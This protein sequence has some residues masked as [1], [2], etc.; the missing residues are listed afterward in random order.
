MVRQ[1]ANGE[2]T[3]YPRKNKQDK[4]IGYRGSYWVRTA[5]GRTR[6]HVSGKTKTEALAALRKATA[7]RDGGLVFDAKNLKLGSYLDRWLQ[8]SVKGTVKQTTYEGYERLARV[9][10]VPT[11]GDAKLSLLTPAH[12]RALYQEKIASGLAATSV[13][14]IHALLHKALRQAVNDGLIPRNVTDAVKA[15]RQQRK[16]MKTFTPE[17]AHA[18]LDA[19]KDDRLGALYVVAI[20]TGVRQGELFGLR[21]EDVDLEAGTLS[22]HRTL[23]SA[24]G[25]P[26]FTTPKSDKAR[27]VRLTPQATAALRDHRKRQAQAHHTIRHAFDPL[28]REATRLDTSGTA[29]SR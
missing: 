27:R 12:I 11:L 8:D 29:A 9:H 16:E 2:G 4:V 1:R 21:W 13:Q 22:V 14:R 20:H 17:Q 10:L 7:D 24:K 18:F 15:P 25:G 23:S 19:A 28:R 5:N 6:R 3:V 26:T